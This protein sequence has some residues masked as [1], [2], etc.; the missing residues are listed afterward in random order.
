MIILSEALVT[1]LRVIGSWC[2]GQHVNNAASYGMMSTALN[3]A[4]YPREL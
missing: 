3:T 2:S 1:A 4:V